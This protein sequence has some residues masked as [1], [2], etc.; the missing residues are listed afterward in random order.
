M[1]LVDTSVWIDH[2]RKG[3]HRLKKILEQESASM[4]DFVLGELALGNF[5]DRQNVLSLLTSLPRCPCANPREILWLVEHHRLMGKGVGYVDACL[6]A[7]ARLTGFRLWTKDLRLAAM[8]RELECDD[9][10]S[11][12]GS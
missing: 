9:H 8:A 3:N 2:F 1:I 4:H 5:R 11:E 6:L 7:S 12:D 10:E